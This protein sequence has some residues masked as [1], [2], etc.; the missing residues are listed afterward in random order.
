MITNFNSLVEVVSSIYYDKDEIE[1]D[2][3][4]PT[5]K[6]KYLRKEL[7]KRYLP[8]L[9]FDTLDEAVKEVDLI[10]NKDILQDKVNKVSITD[11]DLNEVEEK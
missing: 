2:K 3:G 5:P 9:D 8:Q 11:E 6:Q 1:D 7:A 4:N 10:A